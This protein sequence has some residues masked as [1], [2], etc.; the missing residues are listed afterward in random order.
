MPKI[1]R[2]KLK[3]G[4]VKTYTYGIRTVG[5]VIAE[6]KRSPEYRGLAASTKR[7][8]ERIFDEILCL[9][10]GADK[11]ASYEN[12]PIAAIK[13]RHILGERDR[14]QDTPGTA[15]K[16]MQVWSVI[17][18]FAVDREYIDFNPAHGVKYLKGGEYGRW[19]DEAI[20]YALDTVNEN[21]RRAIILAL[22]T[23]QRASDVVRMSW[24]DYDGASIRVRQQKTG[25]PLV[26][27]VHEELKAELDTWEKVATTI[28]VDGWGKPYKLASFHSIMS[29][30][31][32]SHQGLNGC[33]FHGLRKTAAA[34]LAEA[35]CS[36]NE[37]AA[38]TGHRT[39]QMIVH[40]TREAEQARMARAAITRLENE[41]KR[42]GLKLLKMQ[43]S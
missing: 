29:V 19:S 23:G 28:L 3:N 38:V 7:G 17:L 15:N 22:Y 36:A 10:K 20:S 39:L 9:K 27:P 37:I 30:E 35:G 12:I 40:Y 31:L 26:I 18:S 43:G 13:R 34:K 2:R 11:R 24:R 14:L 32:R 41:G 1:V 4:R 33:V 25:E 5:T 8:Y 16:A 21:L 42:T 6:Y